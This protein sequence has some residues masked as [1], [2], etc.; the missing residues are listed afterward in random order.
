MPFK[1]KA[2]ARYFYANKDKLERQ[3]VD[4][5]EWSRETDFSKLPEKAGA[6]LPLKQDVQFRAGIVNNVAPEQLSPEFRKNLIR[7]EQANE[8]LTPQAEKV[9]KTQRLERDHADSSRL[10]V[11]CAEVDWDAHS[12]WD[13]R[14]NRGYNRKL[15]RSWERRDPDSFYAAI[16]MGRE[17]ETEHSHDINKQT[18]TALDHLSED[19]EYYP[20]LKAMEDGKVKAAEINWNRAIPGALIGSAL[21][22]GIGGVGSLLLKKDKD[23][24]VRNALIG[25][26][27]G[28][29]AGGAIGGFSGMPAAGSPPPWTPPALP[30]P[31]PTTAPSSGPTAPSTPPPSNQHGSQ[32]LSAAEMNALHEHMHSLG[33]SEATWKKRTADGMTRDVAD[34]FIRDYT[35]A[36]AGTPG[37]D[38]ANHR[39][40][41]PLPDPSPEVLLQTLHAS[42]G[43]RPQPAERL[44]PQ[45]AAEASQGA[46]T[47]P[48]FPIPPQGSAP[49]LGYSARKGPLPTPEIFYADQHGVSSTDRVLSPAERT[50]LFQHLMDG[51]N[52]AAARK[53]FAEAKQRPVTEAEAHDLRLQYPGNV[54]VPASTLATAET[55]HQTLLPNPW[56]DHAEIH[57]PDRGTWFN[58]ET[59]Q[60]EPM[61]TLAASTGQPVHMLQRMADGSHEPLRGTVAGI[62]PETHS[63]RVRTPDGRVVEVAGEDLVG[64]MWPK[65]P[66]TAAVYNTSQVSAEDAPVRGDEMQIPLVSNPFNTP[67]SGPDDALE[68]ENGYQFAQEAGPLGMGQLQPGQIEQ[69][70]GRSVAWRQGFAEGLRKMGRGDLADQLESTISKTAETFQRAVT[71]TQPVF[72]PGTPI[73]EE[74]GVMSAPNLPI[75]WITEEAPSAPGSVPKPAYHPTLAPL[76]DRSRQELASGIQDV[77]RRDTRRFVSTGLLSGLLGATGATAAGLG[78]DLPVPDAAMLGIGAGIPSSLLGAQLARIGRSNRVGEDLFDEV[79]T[80]MAPLQVEAKGSVPPSAS[81]AFFM[82]GMPQAKDQFMMMRLGPGQAEDRKYWKGVLADRAKAE[83]QKEESKAAASLGAVEAV[84]SVPGTP[85]SVHVTGPAAPG[86]NPAMLEQ[87][88]MMNFPNVMM[89]AMDKVVQDVHSEDVHRRLGGTALGTLLGMPAGLLAA[90]AGLSH[91]A[92]PF[93]AVA[94]GVLGG[95]LGNLAA[96]IGRGKRT[97]DALYERSIEHGFPVVIAAKGNIPASTLPM[98]YSPSLPYARQGDEVSMRLGPGTAEDRKE[99]KVMM[100]DHAN[101]VKAASFVVE[102]KEASIGRAL[103]G[104]ALPIAAGAGLGY[105]AG[106]G[107]EHLFGAPENLS[108]GT[109]TTGAVLGTIASPTV[110]AIGALSG[111]G[112]GGHHLRKHGTYARA[113]WGSALGQLIPM[114]AGTGIGAGLGVLGGSLFPTSSDIP[115]VVGGALGGITG[116]LAAVP[117]AH[118]AGQL[119]AG[120]GALS[121][122]KLPIPDYGKDE[123]GNPIQF[124]TSMPREQEE[125]QQHLGSQFP[126]LKAAAVWNIDPHTSQATQ[127]YGRDINKELLAASQKTKQDGKPASPTSPGTKNVIRGAILKTPMGTTGK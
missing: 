61:D 40:D 3:G 108:T 7:R 56:R 50:A 90:E 28:A 110:G 30:S 59:G 102:P 126:V 66:K 92:L 117:V 37:Q 80:R 62:N 48:G 53:F 52:E 104:A 100:R 81:S 119:G 41:T 27:G 18:F 20:K 5:K 25:A 47:A 17:V 106:E 107:V 39:E 22:A 123:Q 120:L 99:M 84:Y 55:A 13:G 32:H 8:G 6:A 88:G 2:Q 38:Q 1:S 21:G 125:Q 58:P 15:L 101:G 46:V 49:L 79:S 85:G 122:L 94:G 35:P 77:D 45:E 127:E 19:K 109:A 44:T 75:G 14:S 67:D 91:D 72:V 116:G 16:K 54:E 74:N 10:K 4:V 65:Q 43:W 57:T 115:E 82:P 86:K 36:P 69:W 87:R 71:R 23:T 96:R 70:A 51:G 124:Q 11:Q 113:Q 73:T 63:L 105:G 64:P 60:H 29:L 98:W 78:A 118:A 12:K 112:G 68:Y 114:V 9:K 93:G 97:S 121:G 24:A 31:G 33:V 76:V 95:T 111:A 34:A 83:A 26:G 89:D 42:T 103:A